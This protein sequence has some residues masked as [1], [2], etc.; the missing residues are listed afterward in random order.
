MTVQLSSAGFGLYYDTLCSKE[1]ILDRPSIQNAMVNQ[2][3]R[4]NGFGIEQ[5]LPGA[6]TGSPEAELIKCL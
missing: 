4:L 1:Q 6:L 2:Y 5:F 3:I